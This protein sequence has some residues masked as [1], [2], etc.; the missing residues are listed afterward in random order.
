M[1]NRLRIARF[2]NRQ[3]R[4]RIDFDVQRQQANEKRRRLLAAQRALAGEHLVALRFA[5]GFGDVAPMLATGQLLL[6]L[7][8]ALDRDLAFLVVVDGTLGAMPSGLVDLVRL[9][10]GACPM[11]TTVRTHAGGGNRIKRMLE[12]QL[13]DA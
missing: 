10:E 7:R 11:A 9:L 6:A 2:E 5:Y 1:H 8:D 12:M 13:K 4:A 3:R